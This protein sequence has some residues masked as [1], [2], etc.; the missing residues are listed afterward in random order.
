MIERKTSRNLF[1]G[2]YAFVILVNAFVL[3]GVYLNRSGEVEAEV[4]LTERELSLAYDYR[5]ESSGLAMRLNWRVYNPDSDGQYSYYYRPEWLDRAK[6]EELGFDVDK[7]SRKKEVSRKYSRPLPRDVYLV[8]ENNSPLHALTIE[9]AEKS[10]VQ[11]RANLIVDNE[12]D[13]LKNVLKNAEKNLAG[14]RSSRS[15]LY[16]IDAGLDPQTL[17]TEYPQKDRYIITAG[18]IRMDQY[19]RDNENKIRGYVQQVSNA[20]IHVPVKHRD[21]FMR[22]LQSRSRYL[23]D[24]KTPR[25]QA[26]LAYGSRYEP[27]LAAL[28]G[29]DGSQK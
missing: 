24:G 15:R 22:M 13:S 19:Y 10:V 12:D 1:V 3:I 17:R 8:L 21:F 25:Y 14:E 20:T 23:T 7:Y 4:L 28:E 27:W 16:I 5:D 11:A 2:A 29:M 6:L 26:R 9:Q 18:V